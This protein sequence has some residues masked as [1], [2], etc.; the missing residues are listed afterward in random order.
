MQQP[1]ACPRLP[2][3]G[4]SVR[5]RGTDAGGLAEGPRSAQRRKL[6]WGGTGDGLGTGDSAAGGVQKS[7]SE[8][9]LAGQGTPHP[10]G[11]KGTRR[12]G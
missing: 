1:A 6:G 2:W 11:S 12:V 4:L 9:G 7:G 3:H 10:D 8:G 5:V